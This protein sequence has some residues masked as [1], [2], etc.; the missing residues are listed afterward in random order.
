MY[1][2]SRK[3]MHTLNHMIQIFVDDLPQNHSSINDV[4]RE[5]HD[6]FTITIVEYECMA[7]PRNLVRFYQSWSKRM[8][9][10]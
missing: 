7:L 5:E 10:A 9:T 6:L 4:S 3:Y 1:V 8:V 2:Q